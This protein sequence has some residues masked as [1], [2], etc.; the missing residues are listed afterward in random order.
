MQI[1]LRIAKGW[2]RPVTN[3]SPETCD[4]CGAKLWIGP[5]N[6][7]YCD[8]IHSPETVAARIPNPA[9]K[10]AIKF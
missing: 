8:Q 3:Q 6:Q 9:E 4:G 1:Y 5:G 10:T 7:I 2:S